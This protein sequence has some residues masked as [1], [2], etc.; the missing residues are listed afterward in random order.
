MA[1]MV[2]AM[3][4]LGRYNKTFLYH[5]TSRV[6]PQEVGS[7]KTFLQ[8]FY[9]TCNH[10]LQA[11]FKTTEI[12]QRNSDSYNNFSEKMAEL[13]S[14]ATDLFTP[15]NSVDSKC[16]Q[17]LVFLVYDFFATST[18]YSISWIECIAHATS[19]IRQNLGLWHDYNTTMLVNSRP[20]SW[21]IF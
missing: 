1:N 18:W 12:V 5:F 15:T 8:M 21:N 10:Y 20:C 11:V 2:I 7:S 14:K 13:L 17:T 6:Q 4:L 16:K 3:Y 9:F 19:G